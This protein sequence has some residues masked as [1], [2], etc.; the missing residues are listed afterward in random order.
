MIKSLAV[1]MVGFFVFLQSGVSATVEPPQAELKA[2]IDKVQSKLNEGKRTAEEL[3]AELKE[4]DALVVKNAKDEEVASQILIMKA[5]LYIQGLNSP[6]KGL[7][8]LQEIKAKYAATKIG[9][10]VDEIISSIKQDIASRKINAALQ[11]GTLFPAF[12]AKDIDGRPFSVSALKAKVVLV[13][14]WATWSGTCVQDLPNVMAVYNKYHG[15]GFDILGISLD[16]DKAVLTSFIEKTKMPWPQYF[17]GMGWANVLARQFGISS[18]PA[19]F[20]LDG[21]GKILARDLRGPALEEAVSK[22]LGNP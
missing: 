15:Q 9:A 6:E 2:L 20:L 7:E 21:S 19:T 14:F 10:K 3:D 4:F 17:D 5:T 11:V 8:V 22:A 1:V 16:K 13:D 18:I 12:Q